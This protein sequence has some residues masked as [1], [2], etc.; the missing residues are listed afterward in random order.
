[1]KPSPQLSPEELRARAANVFGQFPD[2]LAVY[3]FGSFA[4]G[5]SERES[6]IDLAI[7]PAN[8]HARKRRL[9]LLTELAR[10]GLDDVDLV[11]LDRDDIV[12]RYEALRPNC[13]I[14]A[15]EA[16]DAGSYLS[17]SMRQ[18]FDFLPHLQKQREAY[19]RRIL[20]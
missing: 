6:D 17:K 19:R 3:L 18:Y 5:R 16:F 8:A 20:E 11:F 13:L 1:M 10:V 4:A 15:R 14:Y 9:D 12:L 7:V 2:V